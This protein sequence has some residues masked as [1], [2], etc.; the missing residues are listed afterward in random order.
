MFAQYHVTPS[1]GRLGVV[2]EGR[3]AAIT[4][5]NT[6]LDESQVVQAFLVGGGIAYRFAPTSPSTG[7]AAAPSEAATENAAGAAPS[8]ASPGEVPEADV[9]T[10]P[11]ASKNRLGLQALLM[12]GIT[13]RTGHSQD[14][15][16]VMKAKYGA[17]AGLE[18]RCTYALWNRVDAFAGVGARALGYS[19]Y[20]V[21]I[22]ALASF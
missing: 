12:A 11:Y 3:Y 6:D 7:V 8:S 15:G 2:V 20:D 5:V 10:L 19:W 21:K 17:N 14:T 9:A 18:A 1:V 4:G 13:K 22:G 16:S